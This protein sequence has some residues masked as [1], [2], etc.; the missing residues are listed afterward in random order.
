MLTHDPHFARLMTGQTNLDKI[1]VI[2]PPLWSFFA[3]E[4]AYRYRILSG[5]RRIFPRCG[6]LTRRILGGFDILRATFSIPPVLT[7]IYLCIITRYYSGAYLT[8]FPLRCGNTISREITIYTSG[9]AGSA[10]CAFLRTCALHFRARERHFSR[11]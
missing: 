5:M 11:D 10:V 8:S 1:D 4:Y 2:F 6:S 7:F 9:K 3:C